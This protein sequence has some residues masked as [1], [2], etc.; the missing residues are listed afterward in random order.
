MRCWVCHFGCLKL[1]WEARVPSPTKRERKIST[2]DYFTITQNPATMTTAR[3]AAAIAQTALLLSPC[4]TLVNAAKEQVCENNKN[5]ATCRNPEKDVPC[6]VYMAASTIGADANL[7]IYTGIDLEKDTVV[8]YPEIAIPLL[9]RE[10]GYHGENLD[11]TLWDRYIWDAVTMDIEPKHSDLER[12]DGGAV[13]VPGVGCTINSILEM[14]NILSTHGSVYDTAGLHRARDPGAG[15]FSPYH[16]AQTVTT[17]PTPAGSELFAS[18]GDT[19]I[20]DIPEAIVA[21]DE[22]LDQ[23]EDF[24][25]EY[26]DWVVSHK[27]KL[28]PDVREGLWE[29]TR[30]F[31]FRS[32]ILGALPR[33]TTWKEVSTELV[34]KTENSTVRHF[35]RQDGKRTVEWLRENGKCQDHMKPGRSTLPQAG[36]GA[37]AARDL[38]EGTVV[39]YAPLIHMGNNRQLWNIAYQHD[40]R[41]EGVHESL[42]YQLEDLVINYSF[43]HPNSTLL[44]TPYG[45]MVNY[46]NHHRAR[47][48]VRVQWPTQELVAHKPDW[49]TK[50][51][52][53]LENTH[54]KIGL[55]FD[56]VA[57]R[58]I[59][60][61]EEIFMD[62]G[63]DWIQ[64]WEEHVSNWEPIGTVGDYQHL[65]DWDEDYIR[66]VSE[67]VTNPYPANLQTICKESYTT[68]SA[69]EQ[70]TYLPT[71]RNLHLRV[72]CDVLERT[73]ATDGTHLY[74]VRLLTGAQKF[75]MVYN[76]PSPIGVELVDKLRSA[77]WHLQK[78]F[79]H[80]MRV[81]DDIFPES[82]KNVEE[83]EEEEEE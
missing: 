22:N 50:D 69:T 75:V 42:E 74:T 2:D 7:G 83:E 49:L 78:A 67:R 8:N 58:D 28:G 66:T 45:A 47:A 29:L 71:N 32:Q 64:A 68:V 23:A 46:I 12:E 51:L 61:G 9:F 1:G 11:G 48:N 80:A 37:F 35:I 21:F 26:N 15:A 53:F 57:L 70:N 19:W 43:E 55:S 63:D 59:Q 27:K 39:G 72:Y 18:Y 20:P 10:W 17:R 41:L 77:D 36:R 6:G 14:N 60:E 5:D 40:E 56:Y 33:D 73:E 30:T 31:P 65:S 82:W 3:I 4:I 79:R 25:H 62:Y 16:S 76:V 13:F 38:P 81:P 54:E 52:A 34:R 44:L 24:L